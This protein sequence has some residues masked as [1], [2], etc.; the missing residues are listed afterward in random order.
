MKSHR[1]EVINLTFAELAA[2]PAKRVELTK[3]LNAHGDNGWQAVHFEQVDNALLVFL[4][5]ET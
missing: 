5:K 1:I 3:A 4:V 2:N